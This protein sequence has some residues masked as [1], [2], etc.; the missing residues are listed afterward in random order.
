M[1]HRKMFLYFDDIFRK[2][3]S[4]SHLFFQKGLILWDISKRKVKSSSH[5]E[6]KKKRFNSLSQVEKGGFNALSHIQFFE[7]NWKNQS[8]ILWVVFK[9]KKKKVQFFESKVQSFESYWEKQGSI[10]WVNLQK[11]SIHW[12]IQKRG[13]NSSS[14]I[15]KKKTILWVILK[16][17]SILWILRVSH[18]VRGFHS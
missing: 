9:K 16:K 6:K 2:I 18:I 12:D 5:T 1:N 11:G 15:E 17:S 7:S 14:H 3:N 8:L 4:S 13:F 10:P